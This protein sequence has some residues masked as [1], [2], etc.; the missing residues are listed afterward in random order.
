MNILV[1]IKYVQCLN[2]AV[3]G[4]S[5]ADLESSMDWSWWQL[6]GQHQALDG[7]ARGAL[8]QGERP[9]PGTDAMAP[10]SASLTLIQP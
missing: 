6:A 1:L 4:D 10:P 2:H 5:E 9:E 3:H 7:P 8:G